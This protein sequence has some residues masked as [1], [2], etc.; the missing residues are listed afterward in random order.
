LFSV[1]AVFGKMMRNCY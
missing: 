1:V